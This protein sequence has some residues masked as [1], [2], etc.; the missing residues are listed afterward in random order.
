[1]STL[2]ALASLDDLE[3]WLGAAP[4]NEDRAQAVLVGASAMVRGFKGKTYTGEDGALTD[5]P[6]EVRTVTLLIAERVLAGPGSGV[7]SETIDGYTVRFHDSA[8]AWLLTDAEKAML[9][10]ATNVL[11]SA[12]LEAP[13]FGLSRW[14][15]CDQLAEYDD[16]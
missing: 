3:V 11:T 12:R 14:R 6:D 4:E 10:G 5:V 16:A 13:D 1:M 8:S 15:D 7:Q 9:S 2:P